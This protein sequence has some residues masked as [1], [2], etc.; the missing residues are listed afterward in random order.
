MFVSSFISPWRKTSA[1]LSTKYGLCDLTPPFFLKTSHVIFFQDVFI[2]SY[3]GPET[4]GVAHGGCIAYT[5]MLEE[6]CLE[7]GA[8]CYPYLFQES[9]CTTRIPAFCFL[10]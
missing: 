9:S 3:G 10:D 8:R 1:H 6:R 2:K 5:W 4:T 7:L